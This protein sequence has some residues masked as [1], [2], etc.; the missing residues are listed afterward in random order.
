MDS[1][2]GEILNPKRGRDVV[3]RLCQLSGMNEPSFLTAWQAHT[4]HL[5]L[6]AGDNPGTIVVG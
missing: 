5:Q 2:F 6:T 1:I 3:D 4:E